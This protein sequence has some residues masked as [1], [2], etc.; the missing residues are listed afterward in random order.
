VRR[1]LLAVVVA[2][3]ALVVVA[4]ALPLGALVRSVARD[5]A[6]TAA[7]RDSAALAPVLAVTSDAVL[8][9]AAVD[10]T[11]L[12]AD[13]RLSVVL[14]DGTVLGDAGP[15]DDEALAFARQRRTS[16]SHEAADGLALYSAVVTGTGDVSVIRARVPDELLDE[17]VIAAWAALGAVA[18]ALVVAAAFVADRLARSLTREAVG[19]AATARALA[20][21]DPGA[22]VVP[23]STPELVE[24]AGAL[25][26]LA[27]R[28]DELRATERERVADLSHRLR[29]PL[30]AL[31]LDAERTGHAD[32]I[33]SVDRLEAAV[34]E[35][36]RTARRPLH[37]SPVGARCD[38]VAVARD[39]AAYWSALAE[40]DGR[41][42]TADLPDE[43][44]VVDLGGEEMAAAID[45]LVGNVFAH[46]PD[47][48]PYR[49]SVAR[50]PVAAV[51][52]DDGGPGIPAPDDVLVRGQT[53]AA[54]TGLGLDIARQAAEAAGG[55]IA[56]GPSSMGG[57]R[58]ELRFA[59][60]PNSRP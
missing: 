16:F 58:V 17:G 29:T 23:G 38:V 41:A 30:T 57:T 18:L 25:N 20:G 59:A 8:L 37:A 45:A 7:E 50:G 33:S 28:I 2:T 21:G 53:G 15:V 4:F 12:G 48:T 55:S 10:R 56:I 46:T 34:T 3:T 27:D 36:V 47:G 42:W 31:R 26:L 40:D 19:V 60:D 32:V 14:P 9:E 49:L 54:S 44:V 24:A 13:G 52:V 6:I 51:A 5:R 22:R 1:R 11:A 35:L 39:R 43:P